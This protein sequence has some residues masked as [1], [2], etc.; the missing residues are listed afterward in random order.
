MLIKVLK[1]ANFGT[2]RC[3]LVMMAEFGVRTAVPGDAEA[4]C[5][6]IS[7]FAEYELS[8]TDR[9]PPRIID[10]DQLAED[11]AAGVVHALIAFTSHNELV[12]HALYYFNT[13]LTDGKSIFLEDLFIRTQFRRKGIGRHIVFEL[14]KVSKTFNCSQIVWN[15]FASFT[16]AIAFYKR[17]GAVGEGRSQW[18]RMERVAQWKVIAYVK[19]RFANR[20]L[21]FSVLMDGEIMDEEK[22]DAWTNVCLATLG[23]VQIRREREKCLRL[24]SAASLGAV[25]AQH[26]DGGGKVLGM[27]LFHRKAY[28]SWTGQFL[29]VDRLVVMPEY[30]RKGIGTA[31][32]AELAMI[33]LREGCRRIGFAPQQKGSGAEPFLRAL[34]CVNMTAKE[35][36]LTYRLKA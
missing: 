35:G 14:A 9:R 4:I 22:A 6:L 15:V 36:L 33:A 19:Q 8:P 30:R 34:N 25:V 10:P 26:S 18:W 24:F 20:P 2:L 27:A 1:W 7:E 21:S 23:D 16:E 31:I 11:I 17:I 12:G 5:S 29:F 28:S 32:V 13:S 3:K